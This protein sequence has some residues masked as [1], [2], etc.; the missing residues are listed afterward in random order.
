[1][2]MKTSHEYF[3]GEKKNANIEAR[4]KLNDTPLYSAA[5]NHHAIV[6]RILLWEKANIETWDT[7]NKM[8]LHSISEYD[9]ETFVQKLLGRDADAEAYDDLDWTSLVWEWVREQECEINVRAELRTLI[10]NEPTAGNCS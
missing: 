2:A 8:P 10:N 6:V 9:Q 7:K 5:I 3:A 1:M 4:N